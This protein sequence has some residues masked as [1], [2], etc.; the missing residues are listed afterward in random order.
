MA[1]Y[2]QNQLQLTMATN[3][4]GGSQGYGLGLYHLIWDFFTQK[5][6]P[7]PFSPIIELAQIQIDLG[8]VYGLVR[9]GPGLFQRN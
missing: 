3:S 2:R 1:G 9:N 8:R 7:A 6:I 5:P 4:L